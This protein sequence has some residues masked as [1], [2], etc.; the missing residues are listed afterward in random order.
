[1]IWGRIIAASHLAMMVGG[2][3]RKKRKGEARKGKER[4]GK[5][6]KGGNWKKKTIRSRGWIAEPL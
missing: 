1:M 4:K 2:K 6:R 3:E 5:E